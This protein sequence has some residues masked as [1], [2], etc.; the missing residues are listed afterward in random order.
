[1]YKKFLVCLLVGK[2][3]SNP[4]FANDLDDGIGLDEVAKD[5]LEKS[6][7]IQYFIRSAKAKAAQGIYEIPDCLGAGNQIF[8]PGANLKNATIINLSNNKGTS[9]VCT[10]N[11]R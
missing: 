8:G 6:I 10:K 7:N 9:S 5:D 1:M 11:L 2:L 4:L 3:F